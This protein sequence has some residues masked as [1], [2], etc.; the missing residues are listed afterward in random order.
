M[1]KKELSRQDRLR[2]DLVSYHPKKWRFNLPFRDYS[3]QM[4]DIVPALSGVIGKTSLVAAFAMAWAGGLRIADPTFVPENV[5]LEMVF[6]S[7]LTLLFCA[8]L[9]PYL[10]P[11]GTLSPLIPMVPVMIASG[12]HP[13]PLAILIGGVGIIISS[14]K[15]LTK[16]VEL[17]GIGTKGGII[18][19]FGILGIHSSLGGL[20]GWAGGLG[21]SEMIVPLIGAGLVLYILLTKLEAKWLVIPAGAVIALAVSA[22]YQIYPVFNTPMGLPVLNPSWWWNQRWGI[23]WGMSLAHF[24]RAFP[25]ALLAVVMWPIDALAVKTFQENNY[26]PEAR[27]AVFD[28]NPTYILVALRQFFG[29]LLGGSQIA[30]VWRSFMIPLGTVGRPIGASALM[31]GVFGVALGILGFPIDIAVFPPLMHLVLIFGVY[32]PLL[33][34][35]LNTLKTTASAQVAAVCLIAGLAI[36]PVMGWVVAVAVE[37]FG[38]IKETSDKRK[39]SSMD[40]YLTAGLIILTLLTFAM[41]G[42]G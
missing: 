28:L 12:V 42:M 8:V 16:I 4:E 33:E 25:F 40:R 21:H 34:V 19:L 5:R 26:P 18:L 14:L 31:L 1:T 38:I 6:G 3:V 37:N 24:V 22:I 35:G 41:T 11:P 23:G 36:N 39:L 27:H 32:A 29:T 13:L 17:N 20:R 15:Y 30:A 7:L 2:R 10:G 9:N